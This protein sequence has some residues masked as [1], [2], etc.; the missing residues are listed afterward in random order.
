[1]GT[2]RAIYL[3]HEMAVPMKYV[4]DGKACKLTEC[5]KCVAACSYNAIDLAMEPRTLTLRVGTVVMA[6]GWKPYDAARIDN[7]GFG[8]YPNVISNVMIERLA[9]PNHPT[10]GKILR[11]SGGKTGGS[12]AVIQCG[13]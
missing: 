12:A 2:T 7:L 3:P 1:M 8:R 4:I 11:P 13:R 6:T 10:P 5:A 9:P